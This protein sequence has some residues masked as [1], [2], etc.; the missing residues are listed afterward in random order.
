[1]SNLIPEKWRAWM[2]LLASLIVV[3]LMAMAEWGDMGAK[4]TL[5]TGRT[6]ALLVIVSNV[7]GLSVPSIKPK[8]AAGGA[9]LLAIIIA[10]T[11][12]AC[13]NLAPGYRAVTVTVKVGNET[14]KG[15]AA[16]CKVRRLDCLKK[17]EQDANPT[18]LEECLRPCHRALTAWTTIARPAINTATEGAFAALETARQA[19]RSDSTWIA[20]LRPGV[21]ALA[22]ILQGW[23]T[24]LGD[25]AAGLLK[26][27][28]SVE[29]IACSP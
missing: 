8:L 25:K 26:L 9:V 10:A 23:Q 29:D 5:W 27:L 13:G 11:A 7:L 3:V 21:C 2:G 18:G 28:S 17:H 4:F 12:P 14:G 15:L 24:V 6:A 22:A 16:V 20:K 1:M 19:K